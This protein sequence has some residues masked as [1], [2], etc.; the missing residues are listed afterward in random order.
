[1]SVFK[2]SVPISI[3]IRKIIYDK[4]NDPELRF[5]NDEIFEI[6]KNNGDVDKS[7][8]IDDMEKYLNLPMQSP[9][10]GTLGYIRSP[11]KVETGSR[12]E[13]SDRF[14]LYEKDLND[15][16]SIMQKQALEKTPEPRDKFDQAF[17]WF[18]ITIK[19]ISFYRLKSLYAYC[20]VLEASESEEEKSDYPCCDVSKLRP[21]HYKQAHIH[22][23]RFD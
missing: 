14:V 17:K 18:G 3:Q 5:T 6:I 22:T 11:Y 21:E 10:R 13:W 1:M 8:T 12:P 20:P 2:P 16:A 9:L 19:E 23:S 15:I 4:Y 7:W